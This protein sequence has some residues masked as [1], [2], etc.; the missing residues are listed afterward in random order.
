MQMNNAQ[1]LTMLPDH[2]PPAAK[3]RFANSRAAVRTMGHTS[4]FFMPAV[5]SVAGTTAPE[6]AKVHGI[7]RPFAGNERGASG[8]S[9]VEGSQT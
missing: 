1:P 2:H 7:K 6:L 5:Q 4:A 8:T 3:S 9:S